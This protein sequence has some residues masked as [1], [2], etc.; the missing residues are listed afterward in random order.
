MFE[1]CVSDC[2][3]GATMEFPFVG[4]F[5]CGP[6]ADG[7]QALLFALKQKGLVTVPRETLK[8]CADLFDEINEELYEYTL[9]DRPLLS[10]GIEETSAKVRAM[11]GAVR[12]G[13]SE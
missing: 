10:A 6:H 2:K 5:M 12:T 7:G 11:I 8:E 3:S 9:E 1:C 13:S 4:V